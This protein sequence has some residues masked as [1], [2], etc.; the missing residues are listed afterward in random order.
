MPNIYSYV[1]AQ[2]SLLTL[3]K[4]C[5]NQLMTTLTNAVQEEA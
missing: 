4:G 3:A 1:G 2:C 5:S